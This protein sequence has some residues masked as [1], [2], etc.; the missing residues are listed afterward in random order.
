VLIYTLHNLVSAISAYPA[1]HL[2]DRSS[3]LHVLVFG[4]AVGVGTNLLLA[5]LGGSLVWLTVAIILSGFYIAVEETL[6]K[7]VVAEILPR[8]RR[9]LGLGLL[10]SVN[11]VGDMVSSLYVGSLLQVGRP[12]LAF[13]IAAALGALG[14]AWFLALSARRPAV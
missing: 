12:G 11:A 2:G 8:E 3:K 10:A 5:V 4:Y 14:V 1:G 7:A 13:G 6:E 9:S